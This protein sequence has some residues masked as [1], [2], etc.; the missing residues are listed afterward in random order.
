MIIKEMGKCF[1]KYKT[2]SNLIKYSLF[3]ISTRLKRAYAYILAFVLLVSIFQVYEKPLEVLAHQDLEHQ[4]LDNQELDNQELDYQDL[5]GQD[6]EHQDPAYQDRVFSVWPYHVG[7]QIE[8]TPSGVFYLDTQPGEE[9]EISVRVVNFT[10]EYQTIEANVH[11]ATTRSDGT[12]N[13]WGTEEP[14][15]T[16]L[17]HNIEDLIEFEPIIQ[18]APLEEYI[19]WMTVRVPIMPYQGVLAGGIVFSLVDS[20]LLE[21]LLVYEHLLTILV[22]QDGFV[23]PQVVIDGITSEVIGGQSVFTAHLRNVAATFIAGM[24]ITTQVRDHEGELV[25]TDVREDMQMAP[26]SSL[27]YEIGLDNLQ[28]STQTYQVTFLIESIEDDGVGVRYSWERVTYVQGTGTLVP[29]PEPQPEVDSIEDE[30]LEPEPPAMIDEENLSNLLLF[31]MIIAG[32]FILTLI[33]VSVIRG[34]KTKSDDFEELHGQILATLMSDEEAQ[35]RSTRSEIRPIRKEEPPEKATKANIIVD[36]KKSVKEEQE[37]STGK[38][39][40]IANGDIE[41]TKEKEKA[42]KGKEKASKEK[43][44]VSKEKEKSTNTKAK[45]KGKKEKA[46]EKKAEELERKEKEIENKRKSIERKAKSIEEKEKAIKR[47]E[48]EQQEKVAEKKRKIPERKKEEWDI[49]I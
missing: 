17:P 35:L 41:G 11:L 23:E 30:E 4:D 37:K 26:N 39:K 1:V 42:S 38:S 18:L 32:I 20:P 47:K 14:A 45:P 19:F 31:L 7:N 34:K 25:F 33:V 21:D 6:L 44:K 12:V 46:L 48:K 36:E 3:K 15:D 9:Q 29:E 2:S 27:M 40:K 13:F 22:R 28:M 8:G 43:E 5:D 49:E 10:D 16:T 24:R